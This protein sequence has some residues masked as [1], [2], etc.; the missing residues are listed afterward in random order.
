MSVITETAATR[1]AGTT[2]SLDRTLHG[3]FLRGLAI[4]PD[5]P[6]F[7]TAGR[8][9]SYT[10][11]HESALAWAGA[12]RNAAPGVAG[13]SGAAGSS[14][15]P[16]V[17]AILA[18]KTPEAYIGLLAALYL[19]AV[20]VPVN[21]DFPAARNRSILTAAGVDA[22]ITDRRGLAVLD[23]LAAGWDDAPPLVLVPDGEPRADV[24]TATPPETALEAPLPADAEA[25]AYILFT[26]GST[27]R[28]KGVPTSHRAADSYFRTLD[29]RYGFGPDDVF[30]QTF[31]L[32]FDCAMFDLF[33]AWGAGGCVV[34][35]PMQAYRALPAFLAEQ[36]MTVWFSTPGGIALARRTGALSPGALPGLRWSLFAGEPLHRQDAEDWLRAAPR[37]VVENLY[38]PTELTITV[39]AHRLSPGTPDERYVNGVVP[40]GPV[41]GSLD[42]LLL[43]PDGSVDGDSKGK[44]EGESEGE[45]CITGP[46]MFAGY[47]DP[48]EDAN[49]FL[50]HDGRRWYRT[51]DRVRRYPDGEIA[52]VGRADDQVQVQGWRVELSEVSHSVRGLP[53]V[54]DAVTVAAAVGGSHEL[55]TF[56]TGEPAASAD[57]A[58]RLTADL[59]KAMV[60]RLFQHLEEFPMNPNRKIDRSTLRSRAEAL[61]DRGRIRS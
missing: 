11:A 44:G 39:T 13:S 19:G 7:R 57:L 12:L 26:S 33:C 28:P 14:A 20:A 43:A 23:T 40:I 61:L 59:P 37:S 60:P 29:A 35:I 41:H 9:V 18:T 31:D 50:D 32:T 10:E 4:S 48:A 3:R 58:R 15:G 2:A 46:Q 56:Y 45:L 36:R 53:G 22:V 8:D 16:R 52:Y 38:G 34:P 21:P 47:L 30:S 24:I 55:V 51:G 1:S 27:G 6:A 49:R 25:T 17:V 54:E 5:R 42:A